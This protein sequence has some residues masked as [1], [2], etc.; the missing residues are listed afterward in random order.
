[1]SD[2][3][4]TTANITRRMKLWGGFMLAIFAAWFGI[5][6]YLADLADIKVRQQIALSAQDGIDLNCSN[7]TIKGFPFRIGLFCDSSGLVNKQQPEHARWRDGTP[8]AE[9]RG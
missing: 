2:K 3:P 1:M 5:W 4:K 6:F 7:Q 9:R 8:V